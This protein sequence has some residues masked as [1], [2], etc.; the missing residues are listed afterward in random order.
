M[1]YFWGE[2]SP[3]NKISKMNIIINTGQTHELVQKSE[4][5]NK[6]SSQ[7]STYG[8]YI[9]SNRIRGSDRATKSR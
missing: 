6:T 7:L 4:N 9:G 3:F 1:G 5:Q 2:L 8:A